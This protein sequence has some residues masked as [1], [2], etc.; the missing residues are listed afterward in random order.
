MGSE[1]GQVAG[2]QDS[3]NWRGRIQGR[4]Q[5]YLSPG[6][7]K[8]FYRRLQLLRAIA[9]S[10]RIKV[11]W[12]DIN[13]ISDTDKAKVAL[14]KAQALLQYVTSGSKVMMPPKMFFMYVMNFSEAEA[15]AIIDAAGG[16][17]KMVKDMQG[18]MDAQAGNTTATSGTN[19]E[20]STGSGGRRN[21]LGK[22]PVKKRK[23]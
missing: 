5:Q 15:M 6:L 21:G 1:Q 17:A 14:Q 16:E 10:K 12:S 11:K 23:V 3:I 2:E 20:S 13:T 9:P 8:P 22:K 18:M 19:P 7:I 4:N